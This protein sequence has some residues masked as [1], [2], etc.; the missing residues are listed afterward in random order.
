MPT[1]KFLRFANAERIDEEL[2][3]QRT[4]MIFGLASFLV[5]FCQIPRF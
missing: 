3:T 4:T 2:L 1:S 5:Y